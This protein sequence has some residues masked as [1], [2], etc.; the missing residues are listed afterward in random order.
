MSKKSSLNS[1]KESLGKKSVSLQARYQNNPNLILGIITF[2]GVSTCVLV[3]L[4]AL[5]PSLIFQDTTATGGDMGAHVWWPAFMRDYLLPG[6]RIFGWTM[7][8]YSGFPVGQYYFPVPALI[9]I[10]LGILMP[11]NIAFK[12]TTAIGAIT[13]PISAYVLG[14]SLKSPRPIPMLMSF[15]A[16]AFLFF[17]GDPRA[18]A[19]LDPTQS[20]LVNYETAQ[21]NHWIM[22]GPLLSNMAGEYSFTIALSFSLLFLGAFYVSIRED[23]KRARVAVLFALTILSHLV[24]AIFAGFAAIVFWG[25][26]Y[27]VRKG[28]IKV[29]GYS[30]LAWITV[31][32]FS[33][34]AVGRYFFDNEVSIELFYVLGASLSVVG[35]VAWGIWKKK[36]IEVFTFA[37]DMASLGFGVLISSIW[38]LPMFLRFGYTTNMRYEKLIDNP[39]TSINEIY[40]LYISPAYFL[41]PVFI[42]AAIGFILSAALLRK[43][44]VPL[45]I[46]AVLMAVMFIQWPEGHAWN[47]RFLPFWYL[48]IFFVAAIGYGELFRIP[49]TALARFSYT[50][51]RPML[52]NFAKGLRTFLYSLLI[53]LF[54]ASLIGIP[55]RISDVIAIGPLEGPIGQLSQDRRGLASGWATYNYEGYEGRGPAWEEFKVVIDE[56]NQLEPGR[57]L[58]ETKGG[59][60]GTTLAMTLLPYFTDHKISSQE[61]LYYEAAG[62][63]AYHFLTVAQ[64]SQS[65]SNP[66]RW[67]LCEN[68][69]GQNIETD[70]CFPRAYG[71]INDFDRGV[72][73]MRLMGVRYFFAHSEQVRAKA[74]EHPDLRLISIV[75][76]QDNADPLGWEIYE[77][78]NSN[79][80]EPIAVDPVVIT[81]KTDSQYW[82]QSG[83]KWLWQWWTDLGQFPF[84]VDDGPQQWQRKTASEALQSPLPEEQRSL[85]SNVKV[86]NIDLR[87]D[88]ISF[89]VD[90]VGE[91]VLVKVSY[92]PTFKATGAEEI[93][94]ASPNFMIVVPTDNEVKIELKRDS[95]EWISYFLFLTGIAGCFFLLYLDKG[96]FWQASRK[97]IFKD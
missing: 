11:Y 60:Y 26:Q 32:I 34:G 6:F 92:Y 94:R 57:A 44:I 38:L 40:D 73:H 50:K 76:D 51:K 30:L 43:N 45:V 62:S 8:F 75:G 54:L 12:L 67:P 86:T 78:T 9:T 15:A 87:Q 82:Q 90:K 21:R 97:Y 3:V 96:R 74:Q 10:I 17:G 37:K 49:S 72:E 79:L 61:G 55:Q 66:V 77:I 58:W 93:Y 31:M 83:N 53:F 91:P 64:V 39:L 27:V 69:D 56:A 81:D 4:S 24:V 36:N 23:K 48:F 33:I 80:V 18:N 84:F 16:T 95:S 13:L 89:N 68:V 47:L 22:G 7:D 63:T 25:A 28:Y 35:I 46:T 2:I 5:Q 14:R 88:S 29:I 65:P 59:S 1:I 70:D 71:D 20:T 41:L 85:E 42:P 19:V 52:L